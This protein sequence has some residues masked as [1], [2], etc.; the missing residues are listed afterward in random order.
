MLGSTSRTAV[1]GLALSA[2]ALVAIVTREGYTDA[3][4]IPTKGDVPTNGFGSTTRLDG[5][6]LKLG[7]KTNPVAA[8]QRSMVYIQQGEQRLKQCVKAPLLQAEYDLYLDLLYNIGPAGFCGSTI[9][10]R[11]N[12]QDY[13]G[14]CQA[15]LMWNRVGAQRCDE[16]GNK[17]CAG[18]W[19]SRL[20][21]HHSCMALALS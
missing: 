5:T 19:A 13:A 6:P 10:K 14:A 3:A 21:L 18:L 7:E 9:V 4:I 16:P 8:L 11:L 2:S 1:V 12:A 20:K 15:I 17:V